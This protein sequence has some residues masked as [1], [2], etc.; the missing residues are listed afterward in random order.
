MT[1]HNLQ[2][3]H[4]AQE[5][6]YQNAFTEIKNEKKTSHW[7]WFI[8]PQIAGL[9]NTEISK[10]YAIKDLNE[11][12]QYLKD[13]IL[14]NRLIQ[15]TKLLLVIKDKTANEIFGKPDDLKLKSCMTLFSLVKNP[16]PVFQDVLDRYFKGNKDEKTVQLI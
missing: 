2:R 3:F 14:A 5:N 9:G 8:F 11:A 15:I 10:H 16:N 6:S 12:E 1:R 4:T 13:D 7:M